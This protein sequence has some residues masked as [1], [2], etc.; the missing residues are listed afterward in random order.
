M[1]DPAGLDDAERVR[2][3]CIEA[4]LA[5]YE[6]AA[7]AGLCGEGALEMA[8]SA[9]RRLDMAEVIGSSDAAAANSTQKP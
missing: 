7:I 9:I 5:G 2:D 3:A 1:S 6:D 4:A 8:I